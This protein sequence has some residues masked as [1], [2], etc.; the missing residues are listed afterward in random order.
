MRENLFLDAV[1]EL[2]TDIVESFLSEDERLSESARKRK[3]ALVR[4]TALA[5]C[6]AIAVTATLP[7]LLNRK[8]DIPLWEGGELSA[9]QVGEMFREYTDSASTNAY[10]KVYV[11]DP[12][13][14]YVGEIGGEEYL[15]IYQYVGG[16]KECDQKEFE[17]FVVDTLTTLGDEKLSY[18]LILRKNGV[19]DSIEELETGKMAVGEYVNFGSFN[20][21]FFQNGYINSAWLTAPTN[22]SK[23]Y[24]VVDGKPLLMDMRDPDGE[25]LDKLEPVRQELYRIFGVSFSEA[26]VRRYYHPSEP[27]Y[28]R[29]YVTYSDETR[30][31]YPEYDYIGLT[32]SVY[33]S[34]PGGIRSLRI[35][36]ICYIRIRCERYSTVANARV[37]P[38]EEAEALLSKGYVIGFH[39]CPLCMAMQEEVCFDDYDYVGMEYRT[40]NVL[41]SEKRQV[42]YLRIPFYTFYKKM[43]VVGLNTVYAKTYVPAIELSGYEEFFE[44]QVS[45]HPES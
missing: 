3:T 32:L 7:F 10:S 1:S 39:I 35:D 30:Q 23:P 15:P 43:G 11:P 38:L 18:E 5:A 25:I 26:E 9:S 36:S 13:Y 28:S 27:E 17:R 42:P 40:G 21:R 37:L 33:D 45:K 29:L 8:P 44:S 4:W 6:V 14:L 19:N 20:L 31:G 24:S 2:D 22:K 12:E 34:E 41:D 16:K